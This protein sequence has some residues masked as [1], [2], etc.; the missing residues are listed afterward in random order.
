[1]D[2]SKEEIKDIIW[3]LKHL[4]ETCILNEDLNDVLTQAVEIL[5]QLYEQEA[6]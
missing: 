3:N 5:T 4:E 6:K 1:M 2:F